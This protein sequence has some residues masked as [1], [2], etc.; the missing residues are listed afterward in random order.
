MFG[1]PVIESPLCERPSTPGEDARRIVRHGLSDV[2]AWL[3]ET[4]GPLP[5]EPVHTAYVINGNLI[6]SAHMIA[7]LKAR[8]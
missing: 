6:T 4:P 5:G 1:M 8:A 3:G 2:L 7:E